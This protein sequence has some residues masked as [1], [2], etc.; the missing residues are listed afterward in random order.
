VTGERKEVHGIVLHSLHCY[1]DIVTVYKTRRT[2]G[3]TAFVAPVPPQNLTAVTQS[4]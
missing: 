2:R 4:I 3:A 1:L